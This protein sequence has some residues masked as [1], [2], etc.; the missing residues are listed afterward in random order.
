MSCSVSDGMRGVYSPVV[1]LSLTMTREVFKLILTAATIVHFH[2]GSPPFKRP[3]VLPC[4][5]LFRCVPRT[6][7]HT[8]RQCFL[9]RQWRL[10][11]YRIDF[12]QVKV[13]LQPLSH[14]KPSLRHQHSL[15]V[16]ELGVGSFSVPKPAN[17]AARD[18]NCRRPWAV[19]A[20]S[21]SSF[22]SVMLLAT[23]SGSLLSVAVTGKLPRVALG[24]HES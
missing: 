10:E 4:S 14:L 8:L 12:L 20:T 2:W 5:L 9:A 18:P 6:S 15:S 16:T 13:T 21:L 3:S 17:N 7:A 24:Q 1:W 11:P 22:F 23:L 19:E